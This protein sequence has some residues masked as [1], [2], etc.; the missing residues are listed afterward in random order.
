LIGRDFLKRG[1]ELQECAYI[2]DDFL[3]MLPDVTPVGPQ[4][5]GRAASPGETACISRASDRILDHACTLLAALRMEQIN[6]SP[7]ADEWQ[8]PLRVIHALLAA[9]KLITSSEQPVPEDA[10]P[11]LDMPR[12][13]ALAWLVQRWQESSLFNELK[14]TPGLICEG[15]W[16]NKPEVARQRILEFLSEVPEGVWWNLQSFIDALHEREPDFQRT[17]GDFDTWLIRKE[18][19][20]ESLQGISHWD[21]VDGSLIR[22]FI[23]GPMHWLGLMD[24]AAP[25]KGE[26]ATAFRL[27]SWAPQL[28][29]GQ[30]VDLPE[31]DQPVEAFSD[32]TV[33][34]GRLTPRLGRYQISRF[35]LWVE[36]TEEKYTYLIT[37]ASLNKAGEQGLKVIHLQTLL[38]RYG[39][40]PPPSLIEA[41]NQWD[42]HGG[43]V[44]IHPCIVLQVE[45]PQILKALR[46]TPAGRF[47][48]EPLGPTAAIITPGAVEKVTRTLARLGYLCDV[49]VMNGDVHISAEPDV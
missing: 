16:Q 37:P 22:F 10:R 6:R 14:L 18:E 20:G 26:N 48:S 4:P 24:L 40:T 1:G 19:T 47:V 2:P 25:D 34:A 32:G 43:Q 3:E 42:Q 46:E 49:E 17:A 9:V 8:P 39:D 33:T 5:P 35:C 29:M 44:H 45:T 41:L 21:E 28:L 31:E 27:S 30:P 15:A 11:F 7:A 36:E 38:Q 12:G 23:T 13:E